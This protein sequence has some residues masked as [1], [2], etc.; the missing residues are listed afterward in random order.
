MKKTFL[1]CG[2]RPN[3]M[4]VAMVYQEM[5]KFPHEFNPLIIIQ[6]NI[7]TLNF[8]EHSLKT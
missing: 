5:M 2:A 7:M 1:V 8:L 6:V 3:F 4:K